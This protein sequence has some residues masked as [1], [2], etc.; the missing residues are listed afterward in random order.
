MAERVPGIDAMLVGH[1]PAVNNYR[2]SGGGNFPHVAAAE[3]V[4]SASDEIRNLL[5]GWVQETGEIDPAE[6][7][8][9]DRK[10]TRDGVPVF[11]VR[12]GA[13]RSPPSG[14]AGAGQ[15]RGTRV[16]PWRGTVPARPVVGCG[17]PKVVKAV[18][19]GSG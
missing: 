16:E 15:R 3:Q 19:V 7:A 2:A 8:S 9:V 4:W 11:W 13:G 10:L 12:A 14:T 6:W 18:R 5:I 1:A 17:R